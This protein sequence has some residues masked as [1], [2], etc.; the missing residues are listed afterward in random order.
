MQPL[1]GREADDDD[2]VWPAPQATATPEVAGAPPGGD[3]E[4][5]DARPGPPSGRRGYG[6]IVP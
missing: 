4:R 3:P 6:L 2:R 1:E 5:D